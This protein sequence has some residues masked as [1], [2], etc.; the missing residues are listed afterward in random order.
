MDKILPFV[1]LPL[2]LL[3]SAWSRATTI[4]VMIALGMGALYVNSRPH[5]KNR[6]PF[7]FSWTLSSGIYL[8]LIFEF[9][10]LL[11]IMQMEKI[12]FLLL[13]ACTCYFFYKMKA[14]AGFELPTGSSKGKEYSPVLTSDSHDCQICQIEVNE[15]FFH[16]IWWDCCV[17][18][19][20]YPCYLAGQIF[21]FAT[22]LF[23]TNLALTSICHPFIL[24]GT[25][26]LPEDCQDVYYQMDT[27][28]CF[29]SS[30]YG[31]G[32]LLIVTFVLLHQL[33]VYIPKYSGNFALYTAPNVKASPLPVFHTYPY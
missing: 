17:L 32:Y 31:V 8:F 5:Q 10:G 27:A 33:L 20:N 13:V 6:S 9:G 29:A 16:S 22:L 30:V 1:I 12:V 26:L 28:I 4:I 24:I 19:A 2:L 25:I 23:G 14:I 15:R 7:F 3:L 18:R 21:A 11:A